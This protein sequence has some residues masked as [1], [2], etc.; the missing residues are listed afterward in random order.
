VKADPAQIEQVLVNLVVNA[1]DAVSARGEITIETADVVL[2]ELYTRSHSAASAGPHVVLIV[3]DNGQGMT[4]EVQ[5]RAF[6]PFFTTKPA[7]EGTG[8]GLSTVYGIV[9]QSGGHVWIYSEVGRGTTVKVYLPRT[10]DSLEHRES[11][12]VRVAPA[13]KVPTSIL[14]VEDEENV[15]TLLRKLLARNGYTVAVA[16][17]AAD[18]AALIEREQLRVDLLVT[19]VVLAHDSGRDL[20][21]VV[22]HRQPRARVLYI[23]GYTDDA[24]VRHGILTEEMPFLQ[25]PFS[26]AALLEKVAAVLAAPGV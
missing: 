7:G 25:K 14:V 19:D 17:S 12:V 21:A 26:A 3:S 16:A 23:S 8:L 13:V 20:A 2:D 5:A 15:R 22:Q 9:K 6:E 24:V 11:A 18:A 10:A 1:H 4:A